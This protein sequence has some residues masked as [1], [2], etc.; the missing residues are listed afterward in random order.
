MVKGNKERSFS[1]KGTRGS[2]LISSMRSRVPENDRMWRKCVKQGPPTAEIRMQ[3]VQER[4][5]GYRITKPHGQ[6]TPRTER[7]DK[8]VHF[9][10]TETGGMDLMRSL[11]T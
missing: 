8:S 3:Y 4:D 9:A 1:T 2:S 6:E 7:T 10:G 11:T 5:H